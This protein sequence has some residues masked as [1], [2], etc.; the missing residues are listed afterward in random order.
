MVLQS[1]LIPTKNKSLKK[2]IEWIKKNGYK[3]YFIYDKYD[4]KTGKLRIVKKG[5][6][7]TDNYYRFRQAKPLS[8]NQKKEG[9]MYTTDKL[10][11]GV[12]LIWMY[13]I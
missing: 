9:W 4:K 7:I 8:P 1:V 10:K 13:K 6:H 12:I 5:V 11:N 3:D 2:A